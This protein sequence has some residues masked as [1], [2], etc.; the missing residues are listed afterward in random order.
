MLIGSHSH[1]SNLYEADGIRRNIDYLHT[2]NVVHMIDTHNNL[3]VT[4]KQSA[5]YYGITRPSSVSTV[6]WVGPRDMS[7]TRC[8]PSSFRG[9]GTD[10]AITCN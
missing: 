2:A 4:V 9:V 8:L 6:E 1:S 3:S 5:H 10:I 7:T